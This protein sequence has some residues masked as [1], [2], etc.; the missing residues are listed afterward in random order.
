MSLTNKLLAGASVLALLG[1]CTIEKY[2]PEKR[3]KPMSVMSNIECETYQGYTGD[4]E[5]M[6]GRFIFDPLPKEQRKLKPKYALFGRKGLKDSLTTG[7]RY[8][9]TTDEQGKTIANIYLANLLPKRVN[10]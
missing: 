10:E 3:A 6:P 5:G 9:F 8:C 2:V 1:A 7:E 4:V